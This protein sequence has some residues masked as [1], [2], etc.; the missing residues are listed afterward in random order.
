MPYNNDSSSFQAVVTRFFGNLFSKRQH[1]VGRKSVAVP[2]VL[3]R[4][5][6]CEVQHGVLR[7]APFSSAVAA[8]IRITLTIRRVSTSIYYY[9]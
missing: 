6:A 8:I 3:K 7:D 4:D 5:A 2:E 9:Q 1:L